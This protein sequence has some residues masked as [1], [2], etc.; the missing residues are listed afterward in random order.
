MIDDLSG[1]A[2]SGMHPKN[3]WLLE[4]LVLS[5]PIWAGGC[6]VRDRMRNYLQG[7]EQ[8]TTAVQIG[9][10][11]YTQNDLEQFF[12]SRLSEFLDPAS[13]N[14]AR[15]NLLDTFIEDKLLLGQAE[16]LKI[17]PNPDALQ[18]MMDKISSSGADKPSGR[19]APTRDA[20]L[21]GGLRETLLIQQ[22]LNEH[23]LNGLKISDQECEAY[24]K[25]HLGD[26]VRNDVV[27]VREILV[28]DMTLVNKV[29]ALLKAKRNR[30][31]ADLA[32]LY[33]IGA[34]A[35]DGGDLGSF[36][37]GELPEEFERA[38]FSISP[39]TVAKV[40]TSQYG[41]HIFLVEEKVLAHQQKFYEVRQQIREKLKLE[42]ERE[43]IQNELAALREKT[44][45]RI[46]R[47]NLNFKYVGTQPRDKGQK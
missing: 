5:T 3:R 37:R 20:E 19:S 46:F 45:V 12:N 13:A 32:R 1:E 6:G 43:L 7:E 44:P 15:S 27:H 10:R 38:V 2:A 41:Y 47:E 33:S 30:N 28:K 29:Y 40:V 22:Y 31:F 34:T 18:S 4:L 17:E 26:Y 9:D 35:A 23:V 21:E 39:G 16:Q 8:H 24:Y 11:V 14:Q 36:Q 25:E 42:G